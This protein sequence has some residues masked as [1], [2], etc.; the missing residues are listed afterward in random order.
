MPTINKL[1]KKKRVY[2]N[3]DKRKIRQDIYQTKEWQQLRS[4]Y[5][6]ENPLD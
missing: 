2:Y 6:M 1:P 4:S 5:L 3:S